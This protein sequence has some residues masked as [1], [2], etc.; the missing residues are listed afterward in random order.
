MPAEAGKRSPQ[1]L[2]EAEIQD[3]IAEREGLHCRPDGA[4]QLESINP[5]PKTVKGKGS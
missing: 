5:R 2:F 3:E 1:I 4:G